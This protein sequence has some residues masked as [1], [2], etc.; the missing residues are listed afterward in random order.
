[1]TSA[2]SASRDTSSVVEDEDTIFVSIA[3][4]RDPQLGP[5]ID[6]CL[7]KARW[8][9]R[10]TFGISWDHGP[11]EPPLDRFADPAFRVLDVDWRDS[12]GAC[13]ARAEAMK[14]WDDERWFLQID[15]H[16]RFAQ[17]WDAKLLEQAAATGSAKPVLTTYGTDFI[18][19]DPGPLP[20]DPML[21]EFMCFDDDGVLLLRPASIANW[22]E[23]K[24]PIRAR[25]LGAMLL[26]APGEFVR[27]VPYDPDLYFLGEEITLAVRAF[28]HGYD[29][30]HPGELIVWHQYTRADAP[31]HWTD[32]V[33]ENGV[34]V[35]WFER[36]VPSKR[37]VERLLTNPQFGPYGFGSERS[38][39]DYEAYAGVSFAHRRVQYY[40]RRRLEP[41]NPLRPSDW[42]AK[43]RDYAVRLV[44]PADQLPPPRLGEKRK[45]YVGFADSQGTEIF[46]KDADEEE[47]REQRANGATITLD[48][49]FESDAEPVTWTVWPHTPSTG[50]GEKIEGHLRKSG[51]G[52]FR[53][54][55]VLSDGADLAT[56][57][58]RARPD[59]EWAEVDDGFSL[60]GPASERREPV[61]I[62]KTGMFV[63]ELADGHRSLPEIAAM[64]GNAFDL[65]DP[66]HAMVAAFVDDGVYGGLLTLHHSESAS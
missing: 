53:G 31:K 42:A 21:L 38:V 41:P 55:A 44:V 30:F 46:R 43:T 7:A 66:P 62:N 26:F 29:L 40:T 5:T 37:K 57:Y 48:R 51:D 36:D 65:A 64:I 20:P 61:T 27:D 35:K 10:L 60:L 22:R 1:V 4:Y 3:S 2:N 25:F 14:L 33:V 23:T 49:S 59:M 56:W 63:L 16:M 50:W 47:I 15:S 12:R 13:W 45:W 52:Y 6:D 34:Q 32:H 9:E 19:G 18:P 54:A 17:D 8:P 39:A 11:E 24:R 28:T 58:P